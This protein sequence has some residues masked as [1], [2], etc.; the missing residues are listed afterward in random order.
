MCVLLL[1]LDREEKTLVELVNRAVS[2]Q[3]NLTMETCSLSTIYICF[4]FGGGRTALLL[5]Q[6]IIAKS[7]SKN[8][9][10]RRSPG[11]SDHDLLQYLWCRTTLCE[12]KQPSQDKQP[13]KKKDLQTIIP[14]QPHKTTVIQCHP[15]DPIRNRKAREQSRVACFLSSTT[16]GK[17]TTAS[18][19][20]PLPHLSSARGVS[21]EKISE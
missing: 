1:L 17:A 5:N 10:K 3:T 11:E 14:D 16:A 21:R 8:K 9:R 2:L 12:K 19:H 7:F 18:R 6:S 4:F 13:S 20:A 15:P